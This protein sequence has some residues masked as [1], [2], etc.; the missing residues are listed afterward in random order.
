MHINFHHQLSEEKFKSLPSNTYLVYEDRGSKFYF[1]K[2]EIFP[3]FQQ[4]LFFNCALCYIN[5]FGWTQN[6]SKWA[7]R[8]FDR[9]YLLDE[10]DLFLLKLECGEIF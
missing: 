9:Y 4:G 7:I 8:E 6:I 10:S 5:N 3:A 1:G 2:L